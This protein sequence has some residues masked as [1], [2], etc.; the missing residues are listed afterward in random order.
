MTLYRQVYCVI[1]KE[2]KKAVI[3]MQKP[4]KDLAEHLKSIIPAD[5]PENY[6]INPV[7]N[8]ITSEENIRD[9][10]LAFREFLYQFFDYIIA[11]ADLYD[12]PKKKADKTTDTV[13][14]AIE[15]PFLRDIAMV[16]IHIG[17]HGEL[18]KSGDSLILN[19][20]KLYTALKGARVSKI[21]EYMRH[22]SDCG[23]YFA[24][25]DLG[26]KKPDLSRVEELEISYPDNPIMLM[27][28]KAM[29]DAQLKAD[30]RGL[31][32]EMGSYTSNVDTIFLRCDYRALGEKKIKPVFVFEEIIK[33]FPVEMQEYLLKLHHQYISLGCKY[34]TKDLCLRV[35]FIYS[36]K[37]R[38]TIGSINISPVNGCVIKINAENIN[39]YVGMIEKFPSTIV[40]AIENGYDCAKKNN[41]IA[42]NPKCRGYEF[43]VN[44]KQYF[45]CKH[46]N[47][48]IP[49]PDLT[50]SQI[51]EDWIN[52]EASFWAIN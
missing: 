32:P 41:P 5:I 15:Y 37:S 42:C 10:V 52:K 22:L 43:S 31:K 35:N 6:D 26:L 14:L 47:F 4:L 34:D 38:G 12:K 16:L 48:Y 7:F 39:D 3:F 40:K 36:H 8:Y 27:G 19:G 45:K 24:G 21:H 50:D 46:L 11:D 1:I 49:L 20:I 13:S 28:L 33:T 44:G 9:G 51:I 29:A 30:K 17:I 23:F 25:I 18:S 2:I